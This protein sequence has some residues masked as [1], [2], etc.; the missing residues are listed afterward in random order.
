MLRLAIRPDLG[1][2]K[3]EVQHLLKTGSE[4][5]ILPLTLALAE[6]LTPNTLRR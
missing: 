6:Y 2:F 1:Q 5:D 4:A 3:N